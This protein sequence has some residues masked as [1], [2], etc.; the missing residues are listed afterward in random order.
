M[1]SRLEQLLGRA[2]ELAGERDRLINQVAQDWAQ[3]LRGQPV[4]EQ[5]LGVLLDGLTEEAVRRIRREQKGQWSSQAIQKTA[6]RVASLIRERLRQDLKKP[7]RL[8]TEDPSGER[9]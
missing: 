6:S 1:T 2:R 8:N 4:S 9:G 7:D 3:V 5:D